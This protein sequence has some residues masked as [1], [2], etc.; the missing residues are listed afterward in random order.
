[1]LAVGFGR[2]EPGIARL[3]GN[4]A[5]LVCSIIGFRNRSR[6]GSKNWS[7]LAQLPQGLT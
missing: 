7:S 3:I 5:G 4:L 6:P 2:S 1:M